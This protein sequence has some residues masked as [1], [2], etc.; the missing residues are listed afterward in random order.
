MLG[1]QV[2]VW[3]G[4]GALPSTPAAAAPTPAASAAL[5]AA[6]S[7]AAAAPGLRVRPPGA[8]IRDL[9]PLCHMRCR[10]KRSTPHMLMCVGGPPG[11]P[12]WS[13]STV[14]PQHIMIKLIV[15]TGPGQRSHAGRLSL[16]LE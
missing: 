2:L 10:H 1:W 9:Q 15:L 5:R 8:R 4:W 16:S 3:R 13:S 11:S 6:G 7:C 12:Q 14:E